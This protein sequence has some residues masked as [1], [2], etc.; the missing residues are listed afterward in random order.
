MNVAW[1]DDMM[2]V[3]MVEK[4]VNE[5][6]GCWTADLTVE[7]KALKPDEQKAVTMVYEGAAGLV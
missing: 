3:G 2:A 1:M 5:E 4:M 6:R 7:M